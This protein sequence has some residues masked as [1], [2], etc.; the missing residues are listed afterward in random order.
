MLVIACLALMFGFVDKT[1]DK[2]APAAVIQSLTLLL[3]L[4]NFI[5]SQ[6]EVNDQLVSVQRIYDYLE[7]PQESAL[8]RE[9]DN[10]RKDWPPMNGS[11]GFKGVYMRY[12][13]D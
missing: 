13:S 2:F 5:N 3:V 6:N 4:D 10:E 11:I 12:Q 1:V 8:V 9:T 7:L